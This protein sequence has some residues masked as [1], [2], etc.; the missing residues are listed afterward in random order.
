MGVSISVG[1][2]SEE[3]WLT[4]SPVFRWL[5]RLI[6]E[7][8][9]DEAEVHQELEMAYLFNGIGLARTAQENLPLA[10]RISEL[11]REVALE[12]A[13]GQHL[14]ADHEDTGHLYQNLLEEHFAILAEMLKVTDT[15]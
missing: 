11:V 2:K 1:K 15:W 3:I 10:K 12:F 13:A 9:P 7:K 4:Q 8:H 5:M 6:Q 14:A